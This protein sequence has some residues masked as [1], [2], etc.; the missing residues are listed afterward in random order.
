MSYPLALPHNRSILTEK[1][2]VVGL[3]LPGSV[4]VREVSS[5]HAANRPSLIA[6]SGIF[7]RLSRKYRCRRILRLS[8][9]RP[10]ITSPCRG[11]WRQHI[12]LPPHWPSNSMLLLPSPILTHIPPPPPVGESTTPRWRRRVR[13][14]SKEGEQERRAVDVLLLFCGGELQLGQTVWI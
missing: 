3:V 9:I 4:P 12:I 7:N 1:E 5:D 6:R 13:R 14:S 11:K 8:I 10:D 2:G